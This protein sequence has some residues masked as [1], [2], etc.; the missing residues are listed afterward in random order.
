MTIEYIQK[1]D[2]IEPGARAV[3]YMTRKET[4]R[5]E[6]P[7]ELIQHVINELSLVNSHIKICCS[8]L[9]GIV[10]YLFFSE[11]A[12]IRSRIIDIQKTYETDGTLKPLDECDPDKYKDHN[13]KHL[14]FGDISVVDCAVVHKEL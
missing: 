9:Y 10:R 6:L 13:I 2:C 4:L 14:T 1:I 3:E 7:E 11:S 8:Y 12:S 5:E